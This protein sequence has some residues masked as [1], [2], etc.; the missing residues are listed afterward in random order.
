MPESDPKTAPIGNFQYQLVFTENRLKSSGGSDGEKAVAEGAFAECT[1]LEATMEP[2]VIK[3]GGQNYGSHQRVGT[4][5]FSTVILRRGM[6]LNT[7]LWKWFHEVT[8]KGS[9]THRMDVEIR[10]LDFF[11]QK[12]VRTWKL[13]RALPVKFKSSDLAA[14]GAEIAVEE[15]HLVHEGLQLL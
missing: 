11:T 6:T 10:H 4:V 12:V 13:N 14:K 2:K 8:L 3:E 9:F 15:L 5:S 1:G 7:D